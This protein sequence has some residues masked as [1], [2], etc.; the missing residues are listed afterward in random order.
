MCLPLTL[1]QSLSSRL[2]SSQAR[3]WIAACNTDCK[4]N[5]TL[6]VPS[7]RQ[8]FCN[9]TWRDMDV[10][11]MCCL[12]TFYQ[13]LSE[14]VGSIRNVSNL[15][16]G[17]AIFEFRLVHK[18]SWHVFRDFTQY[19]QRNVGIASQ[20]RQRPLPSTSFPPHHLYILCY[21]IQFHNTIS[22]YHIRSSPQN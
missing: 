22:W 7:H 8:T 12:T 13:L 4:R 2:V 17:G 6:L 3:Q 21:R 20:I 10:C 19:L 14:Q 15:Y 11:M 1:L 5:T 16:L 18:Y 9:V